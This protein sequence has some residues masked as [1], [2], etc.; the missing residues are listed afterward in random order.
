MS[1]MEGAALKMAR[2]ARNAG[3]AVIVAVILAACGKF[4]AQDEIT[5]RRINLVDR[6]GEIKLVIAAELPGPVVRGERMERDIVPAGLIWH[7]SG[8]DESGGIAVADVSGWKGASGGGKVRMITFDFTH[9]LTDAVRLDT[10]ESNDGDA[11]SGGLTV[12]DRRPYQAGTVESSQGTERLFLGTRNGAAGLVIRDT[13]ERERI[14]IGVDP[15][16]IAV[17]ELL[18]E[19]GKVVNR[20]PASGP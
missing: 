5:V 8:G 3:S 20:L 13:E 4:D 19:A 16:G 2:V 9:Q 12:F 7:D 6:T 17:I 14:R 18:D 11:W 1:K 15:D 10:F